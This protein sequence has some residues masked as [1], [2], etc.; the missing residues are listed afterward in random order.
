L[1]E[2]TLRGHARRV[3]V[4][5]YDRWSLTPSV[6]HFGVGAFHR[7]H[8][9]VYFDEIAERGISRGWGLTGVGLHRRDMREA[10]SAQDGLYTVVSRGAS[11]TSARIVGVM[12]SYL[13]APD[14]GAA[15]LAVLASPRTRLVTLTVTGGAYKV[16]LETGTLLVDDEVLADL[17]TPHRPRSALGYLV[18]A[19]DRRREDGLAPFTVLSCDNMPGNGMI[20][21]TAVTEFARLRDPGL[22]EWIQERTAFP[23][24]MVDRITP[25]TTDAD[26]EL[27]AREFG[28]EDRWPVMTEPFSHWII[29]DDF[30][31]GRP[32][33]HRVGA[34]FVPDVR[35]YSLMK[36]RMLNGSHCAIGYVGS[37]LG[38]RRI[39]HAMGDPALVAFLDGMMGAEVT[40]L[41]DP[42]PGIDLDA[43]RRTL[44]ERF[45]NP[46]IGDQL[47]RLC[48]N[49]S[50]KVPCHIVASIREARGTGLPH[51]RLTLAVAAW[52]RYL[53]GTD[54]RGRRVVID[55]PMA[56]RLK[57]LAR[58]GG[59][60]PR[61]LL[62]QRT[63]F[64]AL[65]GDDAFAGEVQACLRVID[66]QGVRAA[67]RAV[68]A[69]SPLEPLPA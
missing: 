8:Q 53:R 37:L 51:P 3:A 14:N 1:N 67:V 55:D 62:R 45:A 38:H 25:R 30:S 4:P 20:V 41:L 36:T 43:Y 9:A 59:R 65:G 61:P 12:G 54:E 33:L 24:S 68:L 21:R 46:Q 52:I 40:P 48:R 44:L 32:P 22:A 13:F 42:V 31:H 11:G 69:M 2:G 47:S 28:V 17:R 58:E 5:T 7:S 63:L 23:S 18:E 10:L 27:L 26:R 57:R 16:D 35:P 66:T 34:Q 15:V 19:L 39:D 64:G 49:G 6:V 29:E 50:S 56:D 60:D